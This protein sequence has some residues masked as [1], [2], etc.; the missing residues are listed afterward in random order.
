MSSNN[1][2]SNN[3]AAP[4]AGG[5]K[6]RSPVGLVVITLI[7]LAGLVWAMWPGRARF[8]PA[9]LRP[10][11]KGCPM[12]TSAFVPTDATEVP[13]VDSQGLSPE[14]RNRVLFRLNMEPCSCG[15][16]NSVIACRAN[17]PTCPLGDSLVNKIIA[18]ERGQQGANQK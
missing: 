13:A 3:A 8:A 15:C 7:L 18:E 14:Q 1:S 9:P 5:Q 17:H 10:V 11:P 4:E 12:T 16:N 6:P 2:I